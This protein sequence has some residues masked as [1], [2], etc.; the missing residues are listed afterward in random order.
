M[1]GGLVNPADSKNTSLGMG[2]SIAS[3][4]DGAGLGSC[5]VVMGQSTGAQAA[6]VSLNI[7]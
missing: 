4:L 3:K 1:L 6:R 5:G 7:S 2:L